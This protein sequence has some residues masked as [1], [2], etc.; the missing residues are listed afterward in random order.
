MTVA[1]GCGIVDAKE[2]H[3]GTA[4]VMRWEAK[5]SY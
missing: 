2:R 1:T 4:Y 5:S 3:V